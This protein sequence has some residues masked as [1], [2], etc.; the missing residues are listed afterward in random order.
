MAM[1]NFYIAFTSYFIHHP[2]NASITFK[3]K[4]R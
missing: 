1:S 4:N 2:K 3:M